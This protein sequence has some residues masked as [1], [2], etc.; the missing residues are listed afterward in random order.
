MAVLRKLA[1]P[2]LAAPFVTGGLRT[3]RRPDT[4]LTEAAQPV[5]RAVGDRIPALAV[6]PPRLVRA[7][8]AIQVTAGLLFA[9]GRAPRLA[10]LTLAATLVPASLATHAYWTE[11]DPQERAR[12]R[13][14]F[15]TDLSAL[16]GLL[17]AAADT[18][19]KPS[20]AHRSR[21]ALRRSPAG[22]LS[23]GTALARVR[24][25]ARR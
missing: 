14:H 7:T 3:L 11:E 20:L 22:L 12:Q 21:H 25:G 4:A 6:D 8:G 23:P 24:G 18:H 1:R 19:G 16:G 17:I 2:L 10:A 13:A 9:T 15:L 5:I